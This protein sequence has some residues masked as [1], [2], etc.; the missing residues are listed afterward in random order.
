MN[1]A[2]AAAL[3]VGTAPLHG[4][5]ELG[6]KLRGVVRG[7][8]TVRE[9]AVLFA[10]FH[11]TLPVKAGQVAQAIQRMGWRNL[12][13][14][15]CQHNSFHLEDDP[16]RQR[17]DLNEDGVARISEAAQVTLLR[18]GLL[19]ARHVCE[20]ARNLP[21]PVPVRCLIGAGETNSTF[22]FHQL[23]SGE[24]WISSD[25]DGYK[26]EK[27]VVVDSRPPV[28]PGSGQ[29]EGGSLNPLSAR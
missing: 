27:I 29:T 19:I 17:G 8:L 16:M 18:Q 23:R 2:A 12:T 3:Q 10:S 13:D 22:R 28:A 21:E 4:G 7:G 14:Y 1:D 24:D 9:G 25:L 26:S 15:E 20:L 6:A 5:V 11:E